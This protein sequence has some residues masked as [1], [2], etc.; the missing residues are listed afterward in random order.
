[1]T[2]R[3]FIIS[4]LSGAGRTTALAVLSD[5]GFV[6]SDAVPVA[7][8]P[9]FVEQSEAE[10]IALGWPLEQRTDPDLPAWPDGISVHHIF[11]SADPETLRRRYNESRRIHPFDRGEGLLDALEAEQAASMPR[12]ARADEV[13]DTTGVKLTDLRSA[14]SA[15]AGPKTEHLQIRTQSFSYRSGLP[16]DADMVFDVRWLRNPHYDLDLRPRTG[17]DQS[18]ADYIR[19]DEEFE[20]YVTHLRGLLSVTAARQQQEG[21][22]YFTVAFGCTGGKHR[23]V[24]FAEQAAQWLS[25]QGYSVSIVHRDTGRY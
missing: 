21:K 2:K 25:A 15:L 10:D 8:W 7:L 4:S 12:R 22:A 18:V 1:M 23:S 11:L 16:L 9:A 24:F 19:A 17:K 3:V 13:M 6:A 14:I 5:M 20:A